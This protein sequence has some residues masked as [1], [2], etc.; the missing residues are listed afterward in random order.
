MTDYGYKVTLEAKCGAKRFVAFH[1]DKFM[2]YHT[3]GEE[4]KYR[5][6]TQS[7]SRCREHHDADDFYPIDVQRG[8]PGYGGKMY[9]RD[10]YPNRVDEWAHPELFA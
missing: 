3:A 10:A 7:C 6:S 1:D 2:E 5:M 4:A 8:E 9:W